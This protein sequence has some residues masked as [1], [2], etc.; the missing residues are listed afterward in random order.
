M[1]YEDF[2]RDAHYTYWIQL[3]SILMFL[4]QGFV[5]MCQYMRVEGEIVRNVYT[6][7][8]LQKNAIR[9]AND[10]LLAKV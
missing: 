6:L 8:F 10:F 3:D 1:S 2:Q 5:T 4:A 7:N 9:T